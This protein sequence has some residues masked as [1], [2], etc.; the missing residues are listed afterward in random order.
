MVA[1]LLRLLLA[2]TLLPA[3]LRPNAGQGD[4]PPPTWQAAGGPVAAVTHLAVDPDAPDFLILLVGQGAGRNQDRTQT[5][6]GYLRRAWAPYISNDGGDT[7]QAASGDLAEIEPTFLAIT[8]ASPANTIWV[9]TAAQGLWRSDNGGRTWR[10]VLVWGLEDEWG[11]AL[12]Q[13]ARGRLH[14]LT[15][16]NSRYP[17]SHL[18]T[19]TDGGYNWDRRPAQTFSGR[20]ETYITDLIADPFEVNRLYAPTLGGLLTSNDA[21]FTWQQAALPLPGNAVLRGDI[22]LAADPTQRGRLYL[23]ASVSAE[24]GPIVVYRSLDSGVSWQALPATFTPA[25][26]PS[27]A[28]GARPYHLRLD[29]LNRGQLLLTTNQGLWLS[30]DGGQTWKRA[31]ETLAGVSIA[32]LI[33]I[34][35]TRGRW[36]AI[37]AG[38]IWRTANGGSR[39]QS[40]TADLPPASNLRSLAAVDGDLLALN[41][42]AMSIPGAVQPLWRSRDLGQTWQPTMSGL[43]GVN[44]YR[45]QSDPSA[46]RTVYGLASS[47]VARSTDA[48]RTWLHFTT[49]VSP[50]QMAFGDKAIFI[51]S[52]AGLWRSTD[53]GETWEATPLTRP[54]QAVTSSRAGDVLA[55]SVN[56][57]GKE[58]WRTND[59]GKTWTP[60]APIPAGD[61]THL[62]VHPQ[63]P[64]LLALALRWGGLWRSSDG[65]QSWERS[66]AGIPAGVQW[67]GPAPLQPAGPNLLA[68]FI[69]PQRPAEWWAGRD[70]G[71]VYHSTDSG[72]TWGDA[73]GDLGDTLALSFAVVGEA[74]AAGTA[75]L[76][77][78]RLSPAPGP[79]SL[80]EAIDA[81][82]DILWP[83]D[84]APVGAAQL[85]NLSLRLFAGRS[86]E[87]PPCAWMPGVELW[88]ARDA[89]PLR[90]QAIA[91]QRT[92]EGHPFPVWEVNDIDVS[93]AN[94]PDHKLVFMART[95]PGLAESSGNIWVHAADARTLLPQPPEPEGLSAAPP[96]AIDAI[97]RVVWPHDEAGNSVP[98]EQANL[99][100]ISA[101]LFARDTR[102]ALAP[103]QMPG[104][105]WLVGG[106]DNQVGRRLAAGEAQTV[107]ANGFEYTTFEFNNIDVSLARD[108][109]HHWAFWL[110]VPG[111][112][113]ASNVWVH[114]LD[115]R[116]RAPT[117]LEPIAGCRP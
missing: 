45:L 107:K 95:A 41:G 100:N 56:E 108:P 13:D 10:P 90:R 57:G 65:G 4:T 111:V 87:I 19:S 85:A 30:S 116:T 33:P 49:A 71:G 70:G 23:A 26:A 7:W 86:Q 72:R 74:L 80:P 113:A 114:G 77:L 24:A 92:V 68:V 21:G 61:A 18:Y 102:L 97:I 91:S 75:N 55:V 115:G 73:T 28:G 16:D 6:D 46:P 40:I 76:G 69:D 98:V 32:D 17:D 59:D 52:V 66:D 31:G 39:W 47:G 101:V 104:R 99:A 9:G 43:A 81:R 83:H 64:N 48:G 103:A 15:L 106:L 109:D 88:L 1:G 82:I 12:T 78:I 79:Q 27:L 44:L 20:A 34:P 96:A 3:V 2:L 37:G 25:L 11:Q 54:I 117:L 38:G 58:L 8:R 36:I 5:P 105:V 89:E 67:Q 93:W 60:I 53:R 22:V 35:N 51:A 14:L 50:S 112:D 84:F 29:P 94:D 63:N 110:E 42:G 62:L